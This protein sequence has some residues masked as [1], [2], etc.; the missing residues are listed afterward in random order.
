MRLGRPPYLQRLW[1]GLTLVLTFVLS[2]CGGAG[3]KYN[4]FIPKRVIVIGDEITY[5]GCGRG[6]SNGQTVCAGIDHFDR[7]SINSTSTSVILGNNWVWQLAYRYGLSTDKI[8][9]PL[10]ANQ[11]SL[12]DADVTTAART[13]KVGARVITP[14]GTSPSWT[15]V[16]T[17]ASLI[18]SYVSGDMVVVAG[19]ANDILSIVQDNTITSTSGVAFK[20]GMT[21]ALADRIIRDLSITAITPAKAY[22]IM[23]AAQSYQDIAL[24]LINTKGQRHVFLAPV[25]DFSNSPDLN[26][27]NG[28]CASCTS[29]QVQQSIALF[30]YTLRLLTDGRFEPMLFGANE[31]RILVTSGTTSYDLFYVN[32]PFFTNVFGSVV[33]NYSVAKSVC[34][35]SSTQYKADLSACTWNGVYDSS[36]TFSGDPAYISSSGAYIYTKDQYLTPR[37]QQVIGDTFWGFMRGFNGW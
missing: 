14:S 34:G 6:I 24:D 11:A 28:F 17:Q 29:T 22:A 27:T 7:F 20:R 10:V 1:L 33:N 5:V 12:S 36:A 16:T 15:S 35:A 23:A 9:E 30:N 13:Q 32:I 25:Y 31:P 21:S 26:I 4:E 37:V 18:P 2:A 8:I 19:G 3:T